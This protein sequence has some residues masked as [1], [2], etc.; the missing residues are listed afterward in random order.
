MISIFYFQCFDFTMQ[1]KDTAGCQICDSRAIAIY[2]V[3]KHDAPQY[4]TV[5]HVIFSDSRT[6]TG[7]LSCAERVAT[8]TPDP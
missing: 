2:C 5:L 7:I 1:G 4:C 8:E 3:L 6:D